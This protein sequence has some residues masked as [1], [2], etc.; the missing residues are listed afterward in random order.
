MPHARHIADR[1]RGASFATLAAVVALAF[2]LALGGCASA[3]KVRDP[4]A[5]SD[6]PERVLRTLRLAG[7]ESAVVGE[8]RGTAVA[9]IEV[10]AISSAGDVEIAWQLGVAALSEAYPRARTYV[11]QLFGPGTVALV[12]LSLPGRDARGAVG[13]DDAAA[14]REMADARYLLTDVADKTVLRAVAPRDAVAVPGDVLAMGAQLSGAYL[15]AKNRAAGLSGGTARIAVRARRAA[16]RSRLAVPGRAAPGADEDAGLLLAA[17]LTDLLGEEAPAGETDVGGAP[18]LR[19]LAASVTANAPPEQVLA[20]RT[21]LAVAEA[22]TAKKPFGSV[23][24]AARETARAVATTALPDRKST[25]LEGRLADAVLVAAKS[26]DAPDSMRAVTDF[27]RAER[28]DVS[29][30]S[31]S[32]KPVTPADNPASLAT[33]TPTASEDESTALPREVLS[34]SAR[35]ASDAGPPAV[36]WETTAGARA[37]VA[38]AVWLA[39]GRSD[40]ARYWLA[41]AGGPVALTDASVDG[42]AWRNRRAAVVDASDVGVVLSAIELR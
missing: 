37:Q 11:V 38:P 39:Y 29:A 28:F 14:L 16:E 24:A 27:M 10:P 4:L 18:L 32:A 6:S 17:R 21:R 7:I 42:W 12:E 35:D 20:L 23:L 41:G 40:G 36:S 2:V 33:A 31:A 19:D 13:S 8:E 34:R 30:A 25:Y 9:R 3:E 26:P 5:P 22:L 1:S 15:D